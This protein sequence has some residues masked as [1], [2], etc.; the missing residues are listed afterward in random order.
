MS[1]AELPKGTMCSPSNVNVTTQIV[2]SHQ[3]RREMRPNQRNGPR[4]VSVLKTADF[5]TGEREDLGGTTL[6]D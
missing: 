6:D 2:T 5:I 3:L 1:A 4:N